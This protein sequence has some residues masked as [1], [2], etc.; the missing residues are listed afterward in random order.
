MKIAAFSDTH[1]CLKKYLLPKIESDTDVVCI[2][3]DIVPLE[4]QR[5]ENFTLI[6]FI[7][8][9]CRWVKGLDVKKVIFIGGNHDFWFQNWGVE[10]VREM[11]KENGLE[12]KLVYLFDDSYTFEDKKFFGTPW[13]INLRNWAFY[14]QNPSET[15]EVIEDCD[16]LITH[17][18]PLYKGVG[19]S[20]PNTKYEREYGCSE[21]T[22][23]IKKRNIRFNICGHIHT[24]IHGGV[25]MDG[26]MVYN[27]SMLNEDYK[28]KYE[29]TYFEI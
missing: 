1:G 14:T 7:D 22:E 10:K 3:G 4:C 28:E 29:V 6:W 9:F 23:I 5:S 21:L 19:M 24:G 8:E 11:I 18:P 25:D 15:F 16:V 17:L 26:T 27:V 20:N 2:A 12:E 13:I